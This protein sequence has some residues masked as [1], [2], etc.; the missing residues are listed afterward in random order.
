MSELISIFR[1]SIKKESISMF[2][3]SLCQFGISEILVERLL[4]IFKSSS[5][6]PMKFLFKDLIKALKTFLRVFP[7]HST[8][9]QNANSS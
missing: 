4:S 7:A 3:F 1:M 5:F 8:T 6:M 9:F 2:M